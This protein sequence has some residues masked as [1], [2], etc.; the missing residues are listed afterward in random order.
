M[1]K[2]YKDGMKIVGRPSWSDV[3]DEVD[4]LLEDKTLEELV[5]V[6]HVTGRFLRL[7]LPMLWVFCN[8][9]AL[10]HAKRVQER[11]CPRSLRN[12]VAAGE[13]CCCRKG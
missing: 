7:P 4:E 6:L 3:K 8:K 11:G 2:Y 5:D 13:T 10:K 9:T 1:Y 12:C